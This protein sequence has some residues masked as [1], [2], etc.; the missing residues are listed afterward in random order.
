[1][2]KASWSIIALF[3]ISCLDDPDC[4]QL[5]QNIIGISFRVLGATQPDTLYLLRIEIPGT[6]S[7]F[8]ETTARTS[9]ELPLN[10]T[11]NETDITFTHVKKNSVATNFLNLGYATKTQFVSDDCGSRYILSDLEVLGHDF[12]SIRIVD[13]NADKQA[14]NNIEIYRCPEPTFLTVV[15]RDLYFSAGREAIRTGSIALDGITATGSA[16]VYYP[17]ANQATF[18]LPVDTTSTETTFTFTQPDGT[19]TTLTMS[20]TSAFQKRYSVCPTKTYISNLKVADSDFVRA[21]MVRDAQGVQK[22]TITDPPQP[23]VYVYRCQR[24]NLLKIDFRQRVSGTSNSFKADTVFLKSVR[25]NYTSQ[26]FYSNQLATTVTV[27][28]DETQNASDIYLEYETTTDTLRLNYTRSAPTTLIDD[29][30]A[31]TLFSDIQLTKP[32]TGVAVKSGADSLRFPPV[33][34]IEILH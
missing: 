19:E 28:V 34:N 23:N 17:N 30:G 13:R 29:C 26:I 25:A 24:T 2:K 15:F 14:R 3:A 12:D 6:D 5:N 8:H 11:T 31:Q 33:T 1:M 32:V 27:P 20:Y 10:F 9:V 4:F 21:E 7:V 22:S 18:Y 16:E